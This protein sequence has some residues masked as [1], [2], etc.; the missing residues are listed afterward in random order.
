MIL[1]GN[2][3]V[4]Y[5][6]ISSITCIEDISNTKANSCIVF[7]YCEDILNYAFLNNVRCAIKVSN[8]KESIL[9]NSLNVKYILCEKKSFAK[10]I[11][12]IAE[13]YMF[14]SKILF[15]IEHDGEIEDIA[16]LGIDGVI[17]KDIL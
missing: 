16:R 14:D 2:K 17:Y 5:E 9:A 4:P 11:Q 7:N 6:D 8:I 15:I 3:L 12:S 10:E 1:L 13:N